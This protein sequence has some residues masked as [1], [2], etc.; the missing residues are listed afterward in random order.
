MQ[1]GTRVYCQH[2]FSQQRA[3]RMEDSG[4]KALGGRGRAVASRWLLITYKDLYFNLQPISNH[5]M[6]GA[7]AGGESAQI[8]SRMAFQNGHPKGSVGAIQ[9]RNTRS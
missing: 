5:R 2:E 9:K 4:K 3:Q 8:W 7:G 1:E 6:S